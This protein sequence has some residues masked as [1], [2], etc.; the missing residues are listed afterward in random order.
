MWTVPS[1]GMYTYRARVIASI[2]TS[3]SL[4]LQSQAEATAMLR[5][6]DLAVLAMGF[7]V[8]NTTSHSY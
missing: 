2:D 6:N 8:G 5:T 7:L 4:H 1:D 3:C